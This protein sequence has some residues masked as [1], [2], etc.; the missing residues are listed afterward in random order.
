[1]AF[2]LPD[3]AV[4]PSLTGIVNVA[5]GCR[6]CSDSPADYVPAVYEI[7]G[8]I[9]PSRDLGVASSEMAG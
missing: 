6:G 7:G 9:G 2:C 3:A 1:M 5:V 8:P 4:R